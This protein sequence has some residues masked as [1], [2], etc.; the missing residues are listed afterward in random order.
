[1]VNL[2]EVRLSPDAIFRCAK[3]SPDKLVELECSGDEWLV[4]SDNDFTVA[5]IG[6]VLD[7]EA[8]CNP[9]PFHLNKTHVTQDGVLLTCSRD[10]VFNYTIPSPNNCN[11]Y[12]DFRYTIFENHYF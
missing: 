2:F 9:E 4:K 12:C 11:L 6:N 7:F 3:F 5:D 1:M 8:S 10:P